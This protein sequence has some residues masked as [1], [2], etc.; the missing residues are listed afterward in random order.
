MMR[1][2]ANILGRGLLLLALLAAGC[3]TTPKGQGKLCID[4]TGRHAGHALATVY[5]D[6]ARECDVSMIKGKGF[7]LFCPAGQHTIKI[8]AKGFEPYE[9]EIKVRRNATTW[10]N[11]RLKRS[12]PDEAKTAS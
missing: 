11:V 3:Q 6:G 8:E 1:F 2:N 9:K 4:V 10:L 5:I 7:F 12:D